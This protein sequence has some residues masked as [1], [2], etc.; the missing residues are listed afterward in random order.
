MWL[1]IKRVPANA[2]L[3][4]AP[5]QSTF[6]RSNDWRGL[7]VTAILTVALIPGLT[8]KGDALASTKR[9]HKQTQDPTNAN[10][11]ELK[12]GV[13]IER[14]LAGTEQHNYRV[15]LTK[16]QYVRV[17]ALQKSID[18]VLALLAPTGEKL[19]EVDN[20]GGSE[21]LFTIGDADGTYRLEVRASDK[22]AKP[23]LYELRIADLRE[24]T[25]KD[26][27]AVAAQK[28]FE[29]GGK[30]ASQRPA[31]SRRNAI[32][33]YEQAM[34]LWKEADQTPGQA[35][36]LN[37]IAIQYSN[38]GEGRKAIESYLLAVKLWRELGD[39]VSEADTLANMGTAYWR[40]GE[41]Q[42][43]LES[44]NQALKL[45]RT[46]GDRQI[47]A[48]ALSNIGAVY[49]S[50]G[51]PQTSLKY[52]NEAL[53]IFQARGARR[54]QA[55]TLNNIATAYQQLG[56]LQEALDAL[57]QVIALRQALGDE[58][59]QSAPL[60]NLGLV[61]TQLG[62]YDASEKYYSLALEI[63]RAS[64]DRQG[65]A[66]TLQGLSIL[67][68]RRGDVDLALK[69]AQQ[70]LAL[71]REVGD[72]LVE[73]YVL[74]V[75]G[76]LTERLGDP[77]KAL[78]NFE[79][80]LTI[81]RAIG[82]RYGEA[83]ALTSVGNSY[84]EL[85]DSAKALEHY[86]QALKLQREIGDKL[87]ETATLYGLARVE[88]KAGNKQ[89]ARARIEQALGIIESTRKNVASTDFR[90]SF[91]ASYQSH[92]D[93]LIDLLMQ[94]HRMDPAAGHDIAAL[95]VS[96]R[97]RARTL[98]DSLSETY[99]QIKEGVDVSLLE[100]ERLVRH[101][102]SQHSDRMT[103]LLGGKHTEE[104][105]QTLQKQVET[106]LQEYRDI[107][108]QMRVKNPRYTALIQPQPLP[109][110]EI[111]KLLDRDTLLLEYALSDERSFVWAIT[112][113]S[114]KGFEL[115]GRAAIEAASDRFTKVITE[116]QN[117]NIRVQIEAGAAL[118]RLVLAPIAKELGQKKLVVVGDGALLRVPFSALPI[119]PIDDVRG[120]RAPANR[121]Y[122]P[123]ILKHEIV[124]LPSASV[125]AVV[126]RETASRTLAD[127]SVA[128]IADP[129]FQP[130]D[131][132]VA[133]NVVSVT[134]GKTLSAS[135]E[136]SAWES[137]LENLQRLP[138]SRREA[139]AIVN[140]VAN[141]QS[142]K[143]LDFAANRAAFSNDVLSRYRVVHFATHA[144]LNNSYP[145]LSGIV[146]S[147][148]DEHGK[149]Q[150]GFVRLYEIYSLRL[151]ADLV[152][153]SACRTAL[154][155]Q[156]RGEGL[157]GLTRGFM[158]AGSPRVVVSLWEVN[159]EAT[160]ELMKR[161]YTAM[162]I[163]RMR[164][165]AALRTAQLSMARTRWWNA[166]YYWAAF[167]LQG[168]FR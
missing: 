56:K 26:R 150:N 27:S 66:T 25:P 134:N 113:T 48:L 29:E 69:S 149:P 124:M 141:D 2:R 55:V 159:D 167:E 51:E 101:Q 131:P 59:G 135:R 65:Q 40:L 146:V 6:L 77:Q 139:D 87:G 47:E 119:P 14:Q 15:A 10:I 144:M 116:N 89:S 19:S 11:A 39:A 81:R 165:A 13:P 157:I 110:K 20:T 38:L 104:Q 22:E 8:P 49:W 83:Y 151:S 127:K 76:K 70:S 88:S 103:R 152:V 147:L 73:A 61:Y 142:F 42:K 143:A 16:G 111:Q 133:T 4:A 153:L 156:V 54:F 24:A 23:G 71:S 98:L 123:L 84:F 118:S 138:Y 7:F 97:A 90:S 9:E 95:E 3:C 67:Y 58:R 50:L 1:S 99:A 72:R 132:R 162:F 17:V 28:L 57:R 33:K 79:Q 35:A 31:D 92:Y 43:A 53:L 100:R 78:T 145:E 94:M 128:V 18:V 122:Q 106:L 45:A 5:M 105:A 107:E 32:T 126:R 63:R 168:E 130:N 155:K 108:A 154:G 125:L 117:R 74:V 161:F 115:P 85:G 163:E 137:G 80:A 148:V 52:Y 91:L 136:R 62:D 164:P 46:A 68:A 114:V 44:H 30:L 166:P 37:A 129:V 82:D 158:Y 109:A 102:L 36:T 140:L 75:I 160:S 93:F 41:S 34:P 64:G 121:A 21:T 86:Q 112:P 120:N 12:L 96:E 60:N